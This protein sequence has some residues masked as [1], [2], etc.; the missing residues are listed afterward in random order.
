MMKN[1]YKVFLS[2]LLLNFL[3]YN[4]YGNND[5][6]QVKSLN[7]TSNAQQKAIKEFIGAMKFFKKN[8]NTSQQ[9]S[10]KEESVFKDE[11]NNQK[12]KLDEKNNPEFKLNKL[13]EKQQVIIEKIENEKGDH[14]QSSKD[15]SNLSDDISS[16]KKDESLNKYE[17][18]LNAAVKSSDEAVIALK[19]MN[20]KIA[21]QKTMQTKAYL[22]NILEQLTKASN[23]KQQ[24]ILNNTQKKLNQIIK[25]NLPK[26]ELKKELKNIAN[27]LKESAAEQNKNGTLKNAQ[28]L[29]KLAQEIAQTA[30]NKSQNKQGKSKSSLMK[31][32]KSLRNKVISEKIQNNGE[33]KQLLDAM[34]KAKEYQKK[35]DFLK[36]HP[37]Y[38]NKEQKKKLGEDI[39][40]AM[41][42]IAQITKRM[43]QEMASNKNEKWSNKTNLTK[44]G[45][46][47]VNFFPPNSSPMDLKYSLAELITDASKVLEQV[48]KSKSL[49]HFKKENVP[50]KYVKEVARYFAALSEQKQSR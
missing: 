50:D 9:A 38:L 10:V 44:N 17:S 15:Q 35:L 24:E 37:D 11:Q 45:S 42:D 14:S 7:I 6:K 30:E 41:Q 47:N 29:A 46:S 4:I 8:L 13:I 20:S 23:K 19:S 25:N 31:Q 28:Q 21:R 34:T 43:K 5:E 32:T 1:I 2:T 36:K 33:M 16:I 22:K 48:S 40:V 49:F 12:Q 27:S 39:E 26:S 18:N 3:C